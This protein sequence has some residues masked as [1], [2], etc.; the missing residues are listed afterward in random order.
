MCD[1]SF[2][3]PNLFV[4][5]NV[6]GL[7]FKIENLNCHAISYKEVR[8]HH[9]FARRGSVCGTDAAIHVVFVTL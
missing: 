3:V 7:F 6:V 1:G 8:S 2:L 9:V 5:T 4:N